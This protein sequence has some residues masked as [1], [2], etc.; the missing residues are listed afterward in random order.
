MAQDAKVGSG[1]KI[2]E[3]IP[4]RKAG[5]VSQ[6]PHSVGGLEAGIRRVYAGI[7]MSGSGGVDG[8]QAR[9][10]ARVGRRRIGTVFIARL[11]GRTHG[12]GLCVWIAMPMGGDQQQWCVVTF[13]ARKYTRIKRCT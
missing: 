4:T 12:E 7:V 1:G 5:R 2:A 13:G 8:I 10:S 9:T 3:E 11:G 6:P